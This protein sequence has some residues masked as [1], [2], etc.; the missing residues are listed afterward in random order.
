LED[1]ADLA[2]LEH[3]ERREHREPRERLER[4][5]SLFL[6]RLLKQSSTSLDLLEYPLR[7]GLR[8]RLR[9]RLD[10]LQVVCLVRRFLL[11]Q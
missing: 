10:S 3:L 4:P 9:L 5:P 6:H 11:C 7:L 2:E 8:L 1:L